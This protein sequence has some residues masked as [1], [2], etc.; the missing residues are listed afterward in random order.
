MLPLQ[1]RLRKAVSTRVYEMTDDPDAR[2]VYFRLLYAA[3]KRRYHVRSYR[4][5]KQSQLQDA[6]RFIENWRGGY[7]E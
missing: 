7:Y 1:L 6:L 2:Q 5:I 4:E 3:L